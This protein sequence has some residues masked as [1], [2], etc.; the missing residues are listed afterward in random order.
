MHSKGKYTPFNGHQF[1]CVIEKTILRGNVIMNK[2]GDTDNQIGYGNF[3][4]VKS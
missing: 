4:E 1:D 3:I 2:S